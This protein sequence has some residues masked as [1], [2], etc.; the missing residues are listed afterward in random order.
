MYYMFE[1]MEDLGSFHK[2]S[3]FRKLNELIWSPNNNTMKHIPE[4]HGQNMLP[5][6]SFQKQLRDSTESTLNINVS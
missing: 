3:D 2:Q 5:I 4:I 1:F 6:N